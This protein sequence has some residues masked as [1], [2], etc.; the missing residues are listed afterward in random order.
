MAGRLTQRM[1]VLRPQTEVH[2]M[3]MQPGAPVSNT[4]MDS[5]R[6]DPSR[7]TTNQFIKKGNSFGSIEDIQAMTESPDGGVYRLSAANGL[8]DFNGAADKITELSRRLP[9]GAVVEFVPDQMSGGNYALSDVAVGA[10][11]G[12]PQQNY[13]QYGVVSGR[14]LQPVSPF[15]TLPHYEAMKVKQAADSGNTELAQELVEDLKTK[16][17]QGVITADSLA[18]VPIRNTSDFMVDDFM[19]G[20]PDSDP[21]KIEWMQNL[22]LTNRQ[23]DEARRQAKADVSGLMSVIQPMTSSRRAQPFAMDPEVKALDDQLSIKASGTNLS[24]IQRGEGPFAD[25][26]RQQEA[27]QRAAREQRLNP[28]AADKRRT[29]ENYFAPDPAIQRRAQQRAEQQRLRQQEADQLNAIDV[30]QMT[31]AQFEQ[32]QLNQGF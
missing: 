14:Q 21:D 23:N 15:G 5:F 22:E 9:E 28:S 11:F 27:K 1:D 19:A 2:L 6:I 3:R 16:V 8:S 30:D 17:N 13:V 24:P 10:G 4:A 7:I 32:W 26:Y 31:D 29:L 18:D 25:F 20:L 12:P